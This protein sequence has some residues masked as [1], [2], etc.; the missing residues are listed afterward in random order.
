MIKVITLL[1]IVALGNATSAFAE[2]KYC[3]DA[4]AKAANSIV[5]SAI[6][7]DIGPIGSFTIMSVQD[8]GAYAAPGPNG[9]SVES[10]QYFVKGL[11]SSKKCKY[12]TYSKVLIDVEYNDC[13]RVLGLALQEHFQYEC[14]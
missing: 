9:Y 10:T 13:T 11:F 14:R 3:F 7:K 6:T 5:E 12:G 4:V 2:R 8:V 1:S